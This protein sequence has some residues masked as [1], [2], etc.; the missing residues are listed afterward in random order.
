MVTRRGGLFGL[1]GAFLAFLPWRRADAAVDEVWDGNATGPDVDTAKLQLEELTR[2]AFS[3]AV[4]LPVGGRLQ[5]PIGDGY[6]RVL[7]SRATLDPAAPIAAQV[8]QVAAL[9]GRSVRSWV[10]AVNREAD[11]TGHARIVAL[12]ELTGAGHMVMAPTFE[13]TAERDRLPV[14]EVYWDGCGLDEDGR[15]LTPPTARKP[16]SWVVQP[17][18]NGYTMERRDVPD[19][20]EYRFWDEGGEPIGKVSDPIEVRRPTEGTSAGQWVDESA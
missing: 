9:A 11:R 10:D 19:G 20:G 8:E 13:T 15:L 2:A 6:A 12:M 7:V 3:A 4:G 14:L 5:H 16:R 18:D 17:V 1:V